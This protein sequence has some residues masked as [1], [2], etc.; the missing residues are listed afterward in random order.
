MA[1]RNAFAHI[2][3][4]AI[5]T[6]PVGVTNNLERRVWKHKH[7]IHDGFTKRYRVTKSLYA[8]EYHRFDD[9]IAREKGITELDRAEA[10]RI[11]RL[12]E[13]VTSDASDS[14]N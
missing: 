1:M 7:F 5:G 13:E 9:A 11:W 3:G 12:R 8:E 6:L 4:S 2:M 14:R 10:M